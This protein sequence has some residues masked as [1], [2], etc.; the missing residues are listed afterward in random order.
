M[1]GWQGMRTGERLSRVS[2]KIQPQRPPPTAYCPQIRRPLPAARKS[3]CKSAKIK[4]AALKTA[5]AV[6]TSP[7][8]ASNVPPAE[9]KDRAR[10]QRKREEQRASEKPPAKKQKTTPGSSVPQAVVEP[11]ESGSDSEA[12]SGDYRVCVRKRRMMETI[13]QRGG[14]FLRLMDACIE[15]EDRNTNNRAVAPR[16]WENSDAMFYR[17]LPRVAERNT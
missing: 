16:T 12:N 2:V 6:L 13:E 14:G 7:T 4:N 15:K 9:E 5:A 8:N 10:K 1:T 11:E 3:A 17:P